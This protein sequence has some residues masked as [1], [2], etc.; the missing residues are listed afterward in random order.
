MTASAWP[1]TRPGA[2]CQ[3]EFR[4]NATVLRAGERHRQTSAFISKVSQGVNVMTDMVS[5]IS[6]AAQEPSAVTGDIAGNVEQISLVETENTELAAQA[7]GYLKQL[8][9]SS[10][11]LDRLVG[12]F[13]HFHMLFLDG[14]DP[15]RGCRVR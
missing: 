9:D 14:A 12:R 8:A 13:I 15:A 7:N 2:E 4:G 5:Q 3:L 6:V 10:A 1:L 11:R